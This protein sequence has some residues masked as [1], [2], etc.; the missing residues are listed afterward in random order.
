[1]YRILSTPGGQA[2]ELVFN[3]GETTADGGPVDPLEVL[4]DSLDRLPHA[5]ADERGAR[6]FAAVFLGCPVIHELPP[7]SDEFPQLLLLLTEP[8]S[9][10]TRPPGRR[11]G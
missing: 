7:P 1:M 8:L 4:I 11:Q 2:A 6:L 10:S 3:R 9:R 5:V